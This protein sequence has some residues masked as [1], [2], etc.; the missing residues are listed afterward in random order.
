MPSVVVRDIGPSCLAEDKK[1]L[2]E[3]RGFTGDSPVT[4]CAK[5]PPCRPSE[6]EVILHY[7]RWPVLLGHHTA[8]DNHSQPSTGGGGGEH[9]KSLQ[10]LIHYRV[11]DN[12]VLDSP[13]SL[14]VKWRC[15][16]KCSL[17]QNCT[18]SH[19]LADPSPVLGSS[20]AEPKNC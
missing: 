2:C 13:I 9:Q 18:S 1:L 11:L 6:M 3:A 10:L 8:Q 19:G 20:W 4:A 15:I 12:L 5:S 14:S 17:T 7:T 16:T